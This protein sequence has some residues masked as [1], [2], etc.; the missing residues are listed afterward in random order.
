MTP[1]IKLGYIILKIHVKLGHNLESMLLHDV[2]AR[3]MVYKIS[4][5]TGA[6]VHHNFLSSSRN[7]I[8][9]DS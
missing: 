4:L 9:G 7:P 3:C 1:V 6:T 8:I 2:A 5:N